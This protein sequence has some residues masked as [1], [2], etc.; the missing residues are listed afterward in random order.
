MAFANA[1][2]AFVLAESAT[3][4]AA[5]TLLLVA[6]S[7]LPVTASEL[8]L[9]SRAS[10]TLTTRRLVLLFPTETLFASLATEPL[11]NATAPDAEALDS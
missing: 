6:F 10:A 8:V 4:R 2:S 9:L 5:V 1:L 7:C 11:P 3:E